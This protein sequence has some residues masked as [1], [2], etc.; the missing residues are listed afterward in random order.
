MRLRRPSCARSGRQC[1][2]PGNHDIPY[3]FPAR[4]LWSSSG[5]GDDRARFCS[6]A[7]RRG[8]NSVRPWRVGRIRDYQL[9]RAR[10]AAP[11]S[12]L[13]VVAL[14]HHLIGAPC[15]A[16]SPSRGARTC[17][18]PSRFR[19]R[20]V[21][22]SHPPGRRQRHEFEVISVT[23]AESS[24]RSH[25]PVSHVR[26]GGGRR[27]AC[28]C[29]NARRTRSAFRPTSGATATG[30]SPRSADSPAAAGP[31]ASRASREP[32]PAPRARP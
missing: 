27:A 25:R 13:R 26:T 10:V 2:D 28:T 9:S 16:R 12:A 4:S 29:T 20:L 22:R 19:R 21:P 6:P 3:T 24:S 1:R 8:I 18:P 11:P 14:H 32:S 17:S 31:S 30:G 7:L 23:C 15:L 5:T